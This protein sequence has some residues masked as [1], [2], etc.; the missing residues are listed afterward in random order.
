MGGSSSLSTVPSTRLRGPP[1]CDIEPV[2]G[3]PWLWCTSRHRRCHKDRAAGIWCSFGTSG[4][5][6]M[7]SALET[8]RRDFG[9]DIIEPGGAEYESARRSVLTSGSPAYVLR[10]RSVGDVRAGVRFAA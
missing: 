9:G 1:S 8:L 7:S 3:R 4:R 5:N 6:I 10:P 2:A